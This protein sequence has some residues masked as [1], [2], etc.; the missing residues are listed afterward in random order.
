M[1]DMLRLRTVP[2]GT[3]NERARSW[4]RRLKQSSEKPVRAEELYAGGHWTAIQSLQPLAEQ[5]GFKPRIWI[6]SAGYGLLSAGDYIHSYSATFSSAHP[7]AVTASVTERTSRRDL[8]Q[9]WWEALA[10]SSCITGR[11]PR[12]LASLTKSVGRDYFLFVASPD[13]LLAVE[14]DLLRAVAKPFPQDRLLIVT[15]RNGQAENPLG[16]FI[17]TSSARLQARVGGARTSL[18]ARVASLVLKKVTNHGFNA[19]AIRKDIQTVTARSPKLLK[20]ERTR[21]SDGEIKVFI[22]NRLK[23]LAQLSFSSLLREF[24]DSGRACEASRFKD[25][26]Y[27]VKENPHK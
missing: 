21:M 9:G 5:A 4:C 2:P 1:P 17:I 22:R 18:N 13:Y 19:E 26:Y 8:L 14:D 24:R 12:S 11:G 15:S 7:D 23:R 6:I 3:V 16:Q 10:S 20:Y 27:E 25:L